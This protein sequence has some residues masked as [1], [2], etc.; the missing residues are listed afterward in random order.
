MKKWRF[1]KR[2]GESVEQ[3]LR[4]DLTSPRFRVRVP[5]CLMCHTESGWQGMESGQKRFTEENIRTEA[6]FC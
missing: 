4:A 5:V 6:A 2:S 3:L 1:Q